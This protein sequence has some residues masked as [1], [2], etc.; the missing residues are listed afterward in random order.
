M[1]SSNS[2]LKGFSNGMLENEDSTGVSRASSVSTKDKSSLGKKAKPGKQRRDDSEAFESRS[3]YT[4]YYGH[5]QQ[6]TWVSPQYIPAGNPG[7]NGQ[8]QQPYPNAMPPAYGP[9]NQAYPTMMPPNNG[10]A[11]PYNAMPTVSPMTTHSLKNLRT[12]LDQY[13]QQATPPRYQAQAPSVP[14]QGYPQPVQGS[15]QQQSWPQPGFSQSPYPSRNA[16]GAP[17]IPYAYGQLPANANPNDPKSQHPIPGSYQRHG[18]NPKTQS[19][20]PAN[21]MNTMQ[22]PPVP[23]SGYGPSQGSPQVTPPHLNYSG[24]QPPPPLP[25]MAQPPYSGS[26]NGYGMMRQGSNNSLPPYHA[27][28][29]HAV[30]HMPMAPQ[31]PPHQLPQ[32]PSHVPNKPNMPQGPSVGNQTFSHL[33]TYGNPASLPQKPST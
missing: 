33:P 16:P 21:G 1:L 6:A 18:F 9:P 15:P 25:P 10:F 14:I 30:Q 20:V 8:A 24:Y 29:Q 32:N 3:Q 17:G 31:M 13:P 7:Y 5:P 12:N 22:A 26:G 28:P 27:P 2:L 19:F 23:Y 4:A 11:P